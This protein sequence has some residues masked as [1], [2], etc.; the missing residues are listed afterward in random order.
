MLLKRY[1]KALM[2]Q[3][4]VDNN[5]RDKNAHG[6]WKTYW[7][8]FHVGGCCESPSTIVSFIGRSCCYKRRV[9]SLALA[10]ALLGGCENIDYLSSDG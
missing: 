2:E 1:D 10:L 8:N 7:V 4:I 6:K 5:T 3:S 9:M